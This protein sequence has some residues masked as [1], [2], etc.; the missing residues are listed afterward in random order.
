M[1]VFEKIIEVRKVIGAFTKDTA[2]YKYK[3]V[4]GTQ[5]LAKI[6]D[7]MNEVGLLLFP[8]MGVINP[9]QFM[10]VANRDGVV[11]TEYITSGDMSYV[12]QNIEDTQDRLEIPW[13]FVGM[14]DDPSKALGSGLTY[15][16]RYFLL[17]FFNVPTDEA[18]PD[19]NQGDKGK[20]TKVEE[21]D[22]RPWMTPKQFKTALDRIEG[23]EEGVFEKC[24]RAFKMKKEYREQ[25]KT[26]SPLIANL[27][28]DEN[29]FAKD[30]L[31]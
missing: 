29:P 8:K 7:T 16:E 22:N 18:D 4:S 30:K 28:P 15:S 26:A 13:T 3:Y 14:Q 5:V 21:T 24:D 12:W 27:P 2:G 23:G 25:L 9:L 19:A 1:N 31:F 20:A 6:R 17:K 10:D 11:H